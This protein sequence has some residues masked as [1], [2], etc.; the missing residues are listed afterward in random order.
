MPD[1]KY[2]SRV[3]SKTVLTKRL[4]AAKAEPMNTSSSFY[5]DVMTGLFFVTGALSFMSGQFILSTLLFGAASLASNL[6]PAT[7]ARI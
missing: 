4:I 5:K 7:P 2:L 1:C 6:N 3:Y